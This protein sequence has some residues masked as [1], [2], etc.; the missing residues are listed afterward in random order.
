MMIGNFLTTPLVSLVL[1]L[2]VLGGSMRPNLYGFLTTKDTKECTK[3]TKKKTT[4]S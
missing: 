2:G 3:D 4:S 1:T